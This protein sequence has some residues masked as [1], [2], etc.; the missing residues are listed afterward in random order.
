MAKKRV[1]K[2]LEVEWWKKPNEPLP[3]HLVWICKVCGK[4]SRT[5]WG[6]VMGYDE[7]CSMHAALYAIEEEETQ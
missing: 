6:G 2:A 7:S 1:D 3:E 4:T 5:R